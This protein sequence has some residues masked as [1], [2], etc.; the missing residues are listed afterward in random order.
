M[1]WL[2]IIG[3]LALLVSSCGRIPSAQEANDALMLLR[4]Y[5]SWAWALGIALLWADV[6]LPVPQT[7]VITAL[8]II[9]GTIV[10]ALLGSIGLIT[11]GLLAYLL[12][13]TSVRRFL[14]R[15]VGACAMMM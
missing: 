7:A 2:V 1:R 8:G 6:V 9:Y 5:E 3:V 10:G 15:L 11:G 12:M 14:L 4:R 13:R